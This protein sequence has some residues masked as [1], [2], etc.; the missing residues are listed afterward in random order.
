MI[1]EFPSR[2]EKF[3]WEGRA[4]NIYKYKVVHRYKKDIF[5]PVTDTRTVVE[6]LPLGITTDLET[7]AVRDDYGCSGPL[8]TTLK[9]V[10]RDWDAACCIHDVM[11]STLPPPGATDEQ[12]RTLADHV[13]VVNAA[14]I[15][16]NTY[17]DVSLELTARWAIILGV[18]AAFEHAKEFPAAYANDQKLFGFACPLSEQQFTTL[19]LFTQLGVLKVLAGPGDFP[20]LD[21]YN[22]PDRV[23]GRDVVQVTYGA[24]D[25]PAGMFRIEGRGSWVETDARGEVRFSF[26]ER[27]RDDWSV[28]L[29]D[30]SRGMRIQLDLH[31]RKVRYR[32]GSRSW[33]DLYD[34]TEAA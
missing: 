31:R 8:E 24:A 10:G 25:N 34:I 28:F 20:G 23:N 22:R 18:L 21:L 15:T 26:F 6:L 7:R 32:S 9:D 5:A 33:T 27:Q 30:T 2:I 3:N 13:M 4:E 1:E 12:W 14:A 11:Y 29:E 16:R 19:Q 17:P